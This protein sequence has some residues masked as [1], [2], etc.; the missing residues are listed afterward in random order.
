MIPD[1]LQC[2]KCGRNYSTNNPGYEYCLECGGKLKLSKA[3]RPKKEVC[4]H[5]KQPH[6]PRAEYCPITGNKY[7]SIMVDDLGVYR[8]LKQLNLNITELYYFL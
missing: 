1:T 2:Q 6:S 4:A 7:T 3:P 5:C 8:K